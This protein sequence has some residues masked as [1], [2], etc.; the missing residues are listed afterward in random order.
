MKLEL[1]TLINLKKVSEAIYN[2]RI[3]RADYPH[4]VTHYAA[5]AMKMAVEVLGYDEEDLTIEGIKEGSTDILYINMGDPYIDTVVFVSNP[6]SFNV[7]KWG[8]LVQ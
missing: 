6:E 5:K 8:D 4:H 3:R 7:D 1:L 2:E